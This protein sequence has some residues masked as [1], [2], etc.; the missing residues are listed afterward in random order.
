MGTLTPISH[1]AMNE[2]VTLTHVFNAAKE[3]KKMDE[4]KRGKKGK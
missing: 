1:Y 4:A 2:V 3:L